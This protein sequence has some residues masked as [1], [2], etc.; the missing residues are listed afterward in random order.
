VSG[1]GRAGRRPEA[2]PP[3]DPLADS[4]SGAPHPADPPSE[5]RA[6]ATRPRR[7]WTLLADAPPLAGRT[8]LGVRIAVID[9]GVNVPHPHLPRVAGAVGF[10]LEGEGSHDA[11]DVL[12]H[13]TAVASAIHEKAP[14][15]ELF[16]VKVFDRVLAT[17]VPTLVRALD[18]ASEQG[19]HLVNLSLGT[20]NPF[21]AE[22]LAGAVARARARGTLVVSARGSGEAAWYPGVLPDVLG[23]GLDEACPREG[24]VIEEDEDGALALGGSPYPR[25]I[26][27]VPRERNLSGISFAVANVTGVLARVLEGRSAGP[28]AAEAL[29]ALVALATPTPDGAAAAASPDPGTGSPGSAATSPGFA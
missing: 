15:A 2:L 19:V 9:S 20:P 18:W 11:L 1:E 21:R 25:P 26:P 3:A 28:G 24:V 23:V 27:G 4:R 13:G 7:R 17:S 22:A 5:P 14:G 29:Q 12:G 8:G 16:A 10:D 6:P